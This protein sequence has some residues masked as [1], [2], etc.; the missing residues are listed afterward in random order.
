MAATDSRLQNSDRNA[1]G[2]ASSSQILKSRMAQALPE[3]P[4]AATLQ[5][6][7]AA[8]SDWEEKAA[9]QRMQQEFQALKQRDEEHK[10][11]ETELESLRQKQQ[12][13]IN[14]LRKA[15]DDQKKVLVEL[16]KAEERDRGAATGGCCTVQ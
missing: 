15:L 2:S 13:E 10:R 12:E 8:L 1:T 5:N 16:Q 9:Q 3:S 6:R 11:K 4:D 7:T 14:A